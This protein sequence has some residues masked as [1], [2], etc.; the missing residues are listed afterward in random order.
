[1]PKGGTGDAY[2]ATLDIYN[3]PWGSHP[4]GHYGY[5]SLAVQGSAGV[6]LEYRLD[7]PTKQLTTLLNGNSTPN[8]PPNPKD[9]DINSYGRVGDFRANLTLYAGDKLI[10]SVRLFDFTIRTDGDRSNAANRRLSDFKGYDTPIGFL[11]LPPRK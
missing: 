11:V 5:W 9:L 3:Y 2:T 1:V 10:G 7:L 6:E 8:Y 4:S